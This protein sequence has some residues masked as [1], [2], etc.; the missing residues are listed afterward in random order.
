M[1]DNDISGS[2][3]APPPGHAPGSF[4]FDAWSRLARRDPNAYFRA[5]RQ[6][7]DALIDACPA[8]DGNLRRLQMRIDSTRACAGTPVEAARQI[9]G[10]MQVQLGM[11]RQKLEMLEREV[12]RFPLAGLK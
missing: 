8:G 3:P 5:R 1:S 11:L 10:L 2:A 7:I 9:T 12:G 4:D 6:A